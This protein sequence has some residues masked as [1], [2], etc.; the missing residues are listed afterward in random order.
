MLTLPGGLASP[1]F[2]PLVGLLV[3]NLGW[4]GTVV[5]LGLTQHLI[6][7]P[8]HAVLLRRRPEDMGLTPDG[9]AA[10]AA[11]VNEEPEGIPLQGALGRLAFW[12]LAA[13]SSLALLAGSG[14]GTH[15][16]AYVIGRGYDPVVAATLR[17]RAF[18]RRAYGSITAA[19]GAVV[20]VAASIGP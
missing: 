2:I 9:I 20:A 11:L 4:R 1:I 3:P 19:Q 10:P 14:V 6:A 16:V 13:S 17:G 5:A 8:L 15:Q 12:T 18:G 7:V